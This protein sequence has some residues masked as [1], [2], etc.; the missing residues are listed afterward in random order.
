MTIVF[1][2]DRSAFLAVGRTLEYVRVDAFVDH[3]PNN[4]TGQLIGYFAAVGFQD[5]ADAGSVRRYCV[6]AVHL[7]IMFT[8][9]TPKRVIVPGLLGRLT[10]RNGRASRFTPSE[11]SRIDRVD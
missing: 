6:D 1:L 5:V 9:K 2:L 4:Q 3:A 7:K 10:R 11:Q 8:A